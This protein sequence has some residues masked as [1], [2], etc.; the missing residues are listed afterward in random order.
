[1]SGPKV[2]K[3]RLF[4]Y[5]STRIVEA[6]AAIL[7]A[8][9]SMY[10]GVIP[11][12]V[13]YAGRSFC[14]AGKRLRRRNY[15]ILCYIDPVTGKVIELD[16][17]WG[18]R[19]RPIETGARI[20]GSGE[21]LEEV[22][23][24]ALSHGLTADG[25]MTLFDELV[26]LD[27]G[28][29]IGHKKAMRTTALYGYPTDDL[30]SKVFDNVNP[31]PEHAHGYAPSCGK[32][33]AH[34]PN[35][36]LNPGIDD[37]H[38]IATPQ[39]LLPWVRHSDLIERFRVMDDPE[40]PYNDFRSLCDAQRVHPGLAYLMPAMRTHAP[41]ILA[42]KE[43][44]GGGDE[45]ILHTNQ[46]LDGR[47]SLA[48]CFAAAHEKFD[49]N[50]ILVDHDWEWFVH[51]VWDWPINQYPGAARDWVRKPLRE[52]RY[53]GDGYTGD[54][55]IHGPIRGLQLFSSL[56]ICVEPGAKTEPLR[57]DDTCYFQVQAGKGQVSKYDMEC[58]PVLED[59]TVY[60]EAG[61]V[62]EGLRRDGVVIK[63]TG[64]EQLFV[65]FD[66]GEDA[67]DVPPGLLV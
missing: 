21:T 24:E 66:F 6:S 67:H 9:L 20:K 37:A 34:D 47:I 13:R 63:N 18:F 46:T 38:H 26:A 32:D 7:A 36:F 15:V 43:L 54:W 57:F 25:D 27:P 39:G 49:R 55:I 62:T 22:F 45:H 19:T 65:D 14:R 4:E 53:T 48:G 56:R 58:H 23:R 29:V 50:R 64:D 1:M 51:Q 30:T 31:I 8:I 42:H 52:S 10:G 41:N 11:I 2:L 35:R 60:N 16:E 17:R 59:D 33:E 28:G 40:A 44:H 12:P 5:P 61:Y 3:Q